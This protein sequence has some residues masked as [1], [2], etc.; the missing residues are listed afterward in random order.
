MTM[1]WEMVIIGVLRP[2]IR[3]NVATTKSHLKRFAAL[4][5]SGLCS[6]GLVWFCMIY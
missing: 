3:S 1:N 2:R 4:C 5:G 6:A